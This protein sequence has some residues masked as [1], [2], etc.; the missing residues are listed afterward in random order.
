MR[1][2][3]PNRSLMGQIALIICVLLF[4]SSCVT[5]EEFLYLNDQV[6]ALNKRVTRLQDVSKELVSVRE[7]QAT[8]DAELHKIREDMQSISGRLDENNR[9]VNR[10]IERD[11]TTQDD[12]GTTVSDLNDRVARLET[13]VRR[14]HTYLNLEPVAPAPAQETEQ[15]PFR[16]PEPEPAPQV[17]Q[18]RPPVPVVEPPDGSP[19]QRLYDVNLALYREEKYEEAIAGFKNFVEKYSK[20]DLADNAQFWVGES[21][22]SLKQYEQAILA[23][24]RVIKDYPKGNK[25][26]NAI[27]RQAVAFYEINDKT[28]SKLLLKK[29]IKQFPKSNEAKIAEARLKA[30]N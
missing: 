21:Y 4:G 2:Y 30:M 22:M 26:P 24:Q 16:A 17:P 19:E 6:V 8:A 23:F 12:L 27:L 7:Q 14:L 3:L 10:A 18:L 29:L 15:R 11:T 20:S 13:E 28:S 1:S 9:L 25:V 5:D